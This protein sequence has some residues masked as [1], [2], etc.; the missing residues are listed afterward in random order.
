MPVSV[1]R[2]CDTPLLSP[3]S[4]PSVS[5]RH[6]L[7]VACLYLC[8]HTDMS[9]TATSHDCHRAPYHQQL[10]SHIEA[11]LLLFLR[12]FCAEGASPTRNGYRASHLQAIAQTFYVL[13]IVRCSTAPR[14]EQETPYSLLQTGDGTSRLDVCT[15][16]DLYYRNP[17]L[18]APRGQRATH[19]SIK[20]LCGWLE[21]VARVPPH[22]QR[23][24]GPVLTSLFRS[25]R[26]LLSRPWKGAQGAASLTP[27]YTRESLGIT[28]AGKSLLAGAITLE[29]CDPVELIDVS[30][31][32]SAGITLTY[33]LATRMVGCREAGVWQAARDG[34]SSSRPYRLVL[35][36]KESVHHAVLQSMTKSGTPHTYSCILLCTKGYPCVAAREWLRRVHALRPALQ[37]YIM[38]DGDPD[39]LGIALTVMGLLGSKGYPSPIA[40]SQP[41]P[42]LS[43]FSPLSGATPASAETA[44]VKELLPLRF[45]GVCPS[46]VWSCN[47]QSEA[48]LSA[49]FLGGLASSQGIPLTMHDVQ[50][51]KR[52][53]SIVQGALASAPE[54]SDSATSLRGC[55]TAIVRHTLQRVLKEAEWMQRARIKCELQFAC[56]PIGPLTF[57]EQHVQ[58]CDAELSEG[59]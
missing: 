27:L 44:K 3:P 29:L 55:D 53:V 16:R 7:S 11:L 36:E 4:L 23:G 5:S 37:L 50:V 22:Q 6:L 34:I 57:M 49:G 26:C 15:E 38:V 52:V 42:T 33:S 20:R 24:E 40:S 46:L 21:V 19:E 25:P 43:S 14:R 45:L 31:R 10:Q 30:A 17:P 48:P 51:L 47:F 58:R 54:A 32:G 18:F 59:F 1:C 28:A 12:D 2:I 9:T 41:K 8:R 56:G 13:Q 39:G 35:I